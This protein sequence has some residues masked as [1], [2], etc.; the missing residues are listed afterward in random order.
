ME[1]REFT[2]GAPKGLSNERAGILGAHKLFV[3]IDD[4]VMLSHVDGM[5][6]ALPLAGVTNIM[7][8]PLLPG[9]QVATIGSIQLR[10]SPDKI[11]RRSNNQTRTM[12]NDKTVSHMIAGR[13]QGDGGETAS[14]M[15]L[16]TGICF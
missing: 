4:T 16:T 12:Q 13:M 5:R 3:E 9:F 15:A 10:G 8:G 1:W 11:I 14:G 7:I 2:F 6:T